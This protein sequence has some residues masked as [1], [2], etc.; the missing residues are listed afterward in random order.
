MFLS[1]YKHSMSAAFFL[2][3]L[4]GY[5]HKGNNIIIF[6]KRSAFIVTDIALVSNYKSKPVSKVNKKFLERSN[7]IATKWNREHSKYGKIHCVSNMF[8]ELR[9]ICLPHLQAGPAWHAISLIW[10]WMAFSRPDFLL[11][12]IKGGICRPFWRF[13]PPPRN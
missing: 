1:N 5:K 7:Q 3:V 6:C 12:V 9:Y 13:L 2:L 8:L 4:D 10:Q 11:R